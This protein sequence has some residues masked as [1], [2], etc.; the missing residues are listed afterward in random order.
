MGPNLAGRSAQHETDSRAELGERLA[1]AQVGQDQQ[2]LLPESPYP[3]CRAFA[4]LT[5]VPRDSN[6][7]HSRMGHWPLQMPGGKAMR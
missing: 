2:G 4:G 3:W 7:R 5:N 1:L 6:E